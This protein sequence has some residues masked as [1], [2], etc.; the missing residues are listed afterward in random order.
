VV[1]TPDEVKGLTREYLYVEHP[2]R[3]GGDFAEW[4]ARPGVASTIGRRYESE[5]ARHFRA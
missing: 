3:R 2:L 4:L 1:L 5:L